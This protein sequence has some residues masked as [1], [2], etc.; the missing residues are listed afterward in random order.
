LTYA[1]F[2]LMDFVWHASCYCVI[3]FQVCLIKEKFDAV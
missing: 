3:L 2:Q 1:E